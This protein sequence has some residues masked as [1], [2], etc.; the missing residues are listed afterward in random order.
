MKKAEEKGGGTL[1][2]ANPSMT[3]RRRSQYRLPRGFI[4]RRRERAEGVT[5][6]GDGVSRRSVKAVQKAGDLLAKRK[7][8]V[9]NRDRLRGINSMN[10][11][12][13]GR[14]SRDDDDSMY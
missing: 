1:L 11:P 13:R 12:P 9:T 3:E 2:D 7:G 5:T 14:P 6:L 8:R 10:R 4:D